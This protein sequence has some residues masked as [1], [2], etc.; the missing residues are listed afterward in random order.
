MPEYTFIAQNSP[1]YFGSVSPDDELMLTGLVYN[2]ANNS[3]T[4]RA[5]VVNT[6]L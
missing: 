5:C 1:V 3:Y 6:F 4:C 2:V